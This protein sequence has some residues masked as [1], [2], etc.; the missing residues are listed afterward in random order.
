MEL[1]KRIIINTET[2]EITET[3]ETEDIPIQEI[4]QEPTQ[5]DRLKAIEDAILI[6]MGG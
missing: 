1:S 2:N 5:E 3:I 6:L 4:I